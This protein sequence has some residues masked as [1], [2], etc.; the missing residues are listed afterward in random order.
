MDNSDLEI[1]PRK[2]DEPQNKEENKEEI[3]KSPQSPEKL[4]NSDEENINED[5]DKNGEDIKEDT[6]NKEEMNKNEI[7]ST[8]KKTILEECKNI[9]TC[10]C[11]KCII[12]R[13][14]YSKSLFS[15][16][17]SNYI[18]ST[19]KKDYS[20][21]TNN[22]S[23]KL[24]YIRAN[25]CYFN[26]G[27]K[28]Y[29]KSSLITSAQMSFKPFKVKTRKIMKNESPKIEFPTIVSTSYRREYPSYGNICLTTPVNDEKSDDCENIPL[30]GKSQNHRDYDLNDLNN[31]GDDSDKKN[32]DKTVNMNL[33]RFRLKDHL[34][35][36]G[37]GSFESTNDRIYKSIDLSD[38]KYY[39]PMKII[40]QAKG[41]S[42]AMVSANIPNNVLSTY[43][44]D[45]IKYN[46]IFP[47]R[48]Y[49]L[50]VDGINNR[51]VGS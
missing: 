46:N 4:E 51:Y 44:R 43:K 23:N 10:T 12:M 41:E 49:H 31:S 39:A 37:E 38:R 21:K 25:E 8:P 42:S 27:Y 9:P 45:Y 33:R 40:N 6:E 50:N 47:K 24:P 18:S 34:K 30:R 15:T 28:N 32:E 1:S 3:E 5:E 14:P 11:G 36:D 13:N 17:Y 16:P 26:K 48:R 22:D 29:L 2:A 35:F 7:L 19:Y 20:Y